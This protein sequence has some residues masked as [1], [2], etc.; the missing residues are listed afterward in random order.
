MRGEGAQE[1]VMTTPA[2]EACSRRLKSWL[3]LSVGL[4]TLV[5]SAGC[6]NQRQELIESELRCKMQRIEELEN[7][8]S[9]LN[10]EVGQLEA[11]LESHQRRAAK[12]PT[13]TGATII[14]KNITLG[15]FTGGYRKDPNITHDDSIQVLLEP[16][17]A[18]GASVKAPGAVHIDVYEVTPQGLKAPLSAW[19]ISAGELRRMWDT[20]LIGGPG[21]RIEL[22]WKAWPTT[23]RIKIAVRFTTLDGQA[24]EAEKEVD[25]RLPE[26]RVRP[27][28]MPPPMM[29]GPPLPGDV[30]PK[31]PQPT[32]TDRP[33]LILP[34][35]P[36]PPAAAS[37]GPIL[38]LSGWRP[39]NGTKPM[40]NPASNVEP[41]FVPPGS[42][43]QNSKSKVRLLAPVGMQPS[44]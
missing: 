11:E 44:K 17:D 31:L 1:K 23:E 33:P 19:D 4:L 2:T 36:Q 30:M 10:G 40:V 29:Q 18:D 16:R 24:Y 7:E 43:Q 9:R 42:S 25:I 28:R 12:S 37:P 39:T 20:P 22:P 21:Y 35:C 15:R 27:Q 13:P 8:R 6:R 34:E 14:V 32:P 26:P 5:P 3:W 38:P 41:R